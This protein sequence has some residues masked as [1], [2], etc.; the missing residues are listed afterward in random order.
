MAG[1]VRV[2]SRGGEAVTETATIAWWLI[3]QRIAYANRVTLV[4]QEWHLRAPGEATG[5]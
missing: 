1:V 2:D 5:C 3:P 4:W